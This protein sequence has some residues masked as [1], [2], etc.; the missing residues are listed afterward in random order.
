M[1]LQRKPETLA[2]AANYD[3]YE[4]IPVTSFALLV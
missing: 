1:D 3:R 2:D 4:Q